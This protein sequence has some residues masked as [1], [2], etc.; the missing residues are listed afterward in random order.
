MP[1]Q[2]TD[3]VNE[4][5]KFVVA[6]QSG[7]Y[8]MSEL[9]MRAGITRRTGYKWLARYAAEGVDGLKER[10]H[11]PEHCPHRMD[12]EVEA[13]LLAARRAHPSWGPRKLLPWLAR[14][15]PEL[16]LPAAST[17]GDLL[18]RE[19]LVAPR[20]RGRRPAHPGT[21]PLVAEAP[22]EVWTMDF[23]GEFRMGDGR[24]CYALTVADAH[25]RFLLGCDA[26]CSTAGEG[27]K[28]CL[29]RLFRTYGL[30][31]AIRSDNGSPFASTAR[32]GLSQLNV[33]WLKLGI[34]H[35]RIPPGKPQQNGAHERM[36]RTLKAETT[37]PPG[38][39]QAAQQARFDDFRAE[40]NEER[41]HEALEQNPP[42]S[43][44]VASPREMPDVLQE[45]EYPGH[46]ERRHVRTNGGFRF[47]GREIFLSEVLCSEW[48]GLEEVE[49]GIWSVYFFDRL[50][51]RLD[52]RTFKLSG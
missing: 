51:A 23:K 25:S 6:H 18:S 42:A 9:C 8:S 35:H 4:R 48:I 36:H 14:R 44:Y 46:Y 2:E 22:N 11:A 26:L 30:P 24:Y 5:M 21:V 28:R 34:A 45:P 10:S 16:A 43:R 52:E 29:E 31:R 15:R 19:G 27:A 20:Q 3:P 39:N 1:W 47:R 13:V 38:G 37:R 32:G 49:D 12:A 17:V 40:Y 41:P 50:L 33:E 7:L